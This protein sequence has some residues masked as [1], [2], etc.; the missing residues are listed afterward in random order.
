MCY[1]IPHPGKKKQARLY[2]YSNSN[3]TTKDTKNTKGKIIKGLNYLLFLYFFF[4]PFVP[5]VV[6]K[7]KMR[8]AVTSTFL[9]F[10]APFRVFRGSLRG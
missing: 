3:F 2:V 7:I 8:I 5:F 4:V 6:K 9:F 10:F 1:I